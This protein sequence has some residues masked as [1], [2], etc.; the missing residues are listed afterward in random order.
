MDISLIKIK[1]ER[2]RKRLAKEKPKMINLPNEVLEYSA[3]S[4]L[5]TD[6]LC[7]VLRSHI[8][9]SVCDEIRA[10]SS[11]Q[12]HQDINTDSEYRKRLNL[13]PLECC[14]CHSETKYTTDLS[15]RK[16][17]K[18]GLVQCTT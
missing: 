12:Y 15:S 1:V 9:K 17:K 7:A 2:A 3:D 5:E 4:T 14:L 8:S 18:E 10:P 16:R 13:F 11:K 6:I